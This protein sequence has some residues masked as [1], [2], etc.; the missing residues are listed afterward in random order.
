MISLG[1]ISALRKRTTFPFVYFSHCDILNVVFMYS[2]VVR[3]RGRND[4][5][6]IRTNVNVMFLMFK[7]QRSR[8]VYGA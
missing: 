7:D 2:N 3:T 1:D 8:K 6:S 4:D 5:D